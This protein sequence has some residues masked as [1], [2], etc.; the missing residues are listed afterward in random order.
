MKAS[1]FSTLLS[2]AET[3]QVHDASLEILDRIGIEVHHARARDIYRRHGGRLDDRTARVTLPPRVVDEFI[4]SLPHTFTFAAQ[5]PSYDRTIPDDAPLAMTASSA[6]NIIDPVTG[7]LARRRR[8]TL[9]APRGSWINCRVS[10]SFPCRWWL[11]M[12]PR[13]STV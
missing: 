1:S 13:V 9:P 5:D 12:P 6:P 7:A 4:V 10:I 8:T 2:A 3:Q 11:T